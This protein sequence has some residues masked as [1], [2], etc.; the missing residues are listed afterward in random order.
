MCCSY[1]LW[2]N[3]GDMASANLPS[4]LSYFACNHALIAFA[5]EVARADSVVGKVCLPSLERM[6]DGMIMHQ[7]MALQRQSLLALDGY[8]ERW[9]YTSDFDLLLRFHLARPPFSVCRR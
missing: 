7:G 2:I 4:L 3:S 5:V 9:R 6:P 1:V 8:N